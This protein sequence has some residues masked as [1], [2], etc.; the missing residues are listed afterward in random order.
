MKSKL[1]L[2]MRIMRAL[3]SFL[4][5]ILGILG[6]FYGVQGIRWVGNFLTQNINVTLSNI[7]IVGGLINEM[8]E[9]LD[10]VDHSLSTVERS[11]IDASVALKETT[12][13]IEKT[14]QIVV[15]DVP[16][17]LDDVQVS[18]PSVIQAAAA[19][20]Q[21][22]Q[23][24]S[25]FQLTIPI[26]FGTDIQLGLG[27]DYDPIVPL[28]QALADL[29]ETLE[30]I[31]VSMRAIEGDLNTAD[32]NI[33]SISNNLLDMASD[34]RVIRKQV[35]DFNPELQ[36]LVQL[37]TTIN[38]SLEETQQQIPERIRIVEYV[39]IG[40]LVLVIVGQVPVAT[41]AVLGCLEDGPDNTQLI[42]GENDDEQ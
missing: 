8:G 42:K 4:W 13:M 6:I 29:S 20:D 28:D 26:P 3:I 30:P 36:R 35:A 31:P 17:V 11:A 5:I 34:I 7:E 12:P 38:A 37:L 16:K 32:T 25:R 15:K 27:I 40:L 24:L 22:L 41:L 10:M 21:T 9:A 23:L 33:S 2:T 14:S 39:W 18:M 1:T 19:V